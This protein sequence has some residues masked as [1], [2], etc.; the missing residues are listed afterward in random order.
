MGLAM[1]NGYYFG[2]HELLHENTK[3]IFRIISFAVA[4]AKY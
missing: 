4:L 3:N 2:L 1:D